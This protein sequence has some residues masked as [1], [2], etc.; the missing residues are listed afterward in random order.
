MD[1]QQIGL[2]AEANPAHLGFIM[3][4]QIIGRAVLTVTAESAACRRPHRRPWTG[5]R[6]VSDDTGLP[7]PN[8]VL[9]PSRPHSGC[10]VPF[11]VGV[12]R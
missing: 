7:C 2:A 4:N 12:K 3:V 8:A 5:A 11:K 6:I 1:V 10:H 9:S